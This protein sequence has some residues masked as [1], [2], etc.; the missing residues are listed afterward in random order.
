MPTFTTPG[1]IL[2]SLEIE[3]GDI[4]IVASERADTTVEVRP[5]DPGK[6][7]DVAAAEQTRVDLAGGRL[8]IKGP[9]RRLHALR[10]AGTDSIDVEVALPAGSDVHVGAGLA[11]VRCT[12]TLGECRL[13]TGFGDVALADTRSLVV[14]TGGGQVAADHVAGDAN[15]STATGTVQ[16]GR[17]DGSAAI[18]SSNGDT[19]LGDVGGDLRVSTANGRITVG[20]AAGSVE[21][22]TAAGDIELGA[23]ARGSVVAKTAFGKVAVG[24]RDGVPAWLDLNTG[25]GNVVSELEA[26]GEPG[27]GEDSV[28][29]KARSGFGDIAIRRVVAAA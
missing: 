14:K 4:R 12:G 19:T 16:L 9:K 24:V 11:A 23:V 7:G 27:A 17:V 1:P 15:V 21:V 3:A 8:T 20:S 28:E 5:S 2:V 13:S 29:I 22:K 18:K 10:G 6:S 25:F 26:A